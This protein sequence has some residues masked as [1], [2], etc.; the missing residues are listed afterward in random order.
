MSN[1]CEN[2]SSSTSCLWLVT[3]TTTGG[4]TT[5]RYY[6]YHVL[7]LLLLLLLPG[8]LLLL[9]LLRPLSVTIQDGVARQLLANPCWVFLVLSVFALLPLPSCCVFAYLGFL[10]VLHAPC[11]G[12]PCSRRLIGRLCLCLARLAFVSRLLLMAAPLSCRYWVCACARVS[13]SIAYGIALACFCFSFPCAAD[14]STCCRPA[15]N[16]Q[17]LLQCEE[18]SGPALE[19]SCQVVAVVVVVVVEVVVVVVVGLVLRLVASS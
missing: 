13:L 16:E 1:S 14:G 18:V 19:S 12:R 9:L 2:D 5:I 7:L 15:A 17:I 10:C 3:T 8:V 4:T 11:S 6:Y